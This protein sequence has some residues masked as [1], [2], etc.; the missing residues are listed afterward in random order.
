MDDKKCLP[1]GACYDFLLR[2]PARALQIQRQMLA[3]NYWT[4]YRVPNG[5]VGERI[6]GAAEGVCSPMGRKMMLA[7]QNP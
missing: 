7:N 4:E 5:G 6:G 3:A 1:K 2:G